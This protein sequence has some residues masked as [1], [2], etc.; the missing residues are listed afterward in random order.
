M[1]VFFSEYKQL[2]ENVVAHNHYHAGDNGSNPR[3]DAKDTDKQQVQQPSK[4]HRREAG[5]DKADHF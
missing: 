5:A 1:S 2:A 3:R 4:D